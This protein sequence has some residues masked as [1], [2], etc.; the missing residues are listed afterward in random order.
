M[1]DYLTQ[2]VES[3]PIL[4]ERLKKVLQQLMREKE[5]A[6]RYI[7]D[8]RKAHF[9]IEFIE[10][11]VRGAK[12]PYYNVP[13]TLLLWQKA[14]IEVFYSFKMADTGVERF[15]RCLLVIARKNGKST[16][17]SALGF[18]EFMLGNGG[19][20]IVCSSNNDMQANILYDTIE[21]TRHLFDSKDK[22]TKKTI[23]YIENKVNHSRV[24]KL[25]QNTQNK[26]GRNI[27][28]AIIDELQE[29]RDNSIIKA[30][31]QSQS[32]K[33]NPKLIMITTEGFINGGALDDLIEYADKVIAEEYEDERFL[34][35]LYMQDSENEVWQDPTS[36][37]KSNPS[38]D[39]IKK[40]DYL[41]QQL[42]QAQI[43]KSERT[44]VLCKD[45]NLKQSA[46][47]AWLL[48]QDYTYKQVKWDLE[49]MRGCVALVG[50]DLS[51]T[52]D[53]TALQIMITCPNDN[54]KYVYSHYFIPESK[55]TN[56][57]DIAAGAH[58]NEWIRDGYIT[59]C[60]G[61]DINMQDIADYL[62]M[63]CRD[64]GLKIFK[65]G[66]DQ[67][68]AKTFVDRLEDCG[69]ETAVV[70]QN[71]NTMSAPM[72]SCEAEFKL[73]NIHYGNNPVTEWC[74]SNTCAYV[75]NLGQTMAIKISNQSQRRIDG[76]VALVIAY[77][78]YIRERGDYNVYSK[79][80]KLG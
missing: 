10:R 11:F 70:Y 12:A 6:D 59:V 3:K 80:N 1:K 63:L 14:F 45:F 77:A 26:D 73:H 62:I 22:R 36:W 44:F 24:S 9:Y 8:T 37:A 50:V 71:A 13:T 32:V 68:F 67:R 41:A 74:I 75:N 4:G 39:V 48:P 47:E 78:I 34:P 29:M 33:T 21:T 55:L 28:F 76:L 79:Y 5:D 51:E 65:V 54:N 58:Y 61:A 31:E 52:T 15:Q 60:S 66:Y 46:S 49:N 18:C 56:S 53:L 42:Q 16:L 19:K 7:Y 30:I 43:S 69:I 20:D 64:Y 17:A 57:P 72:R 40:R 38:I 2:Y 27:D 25:N 35:W 23:S